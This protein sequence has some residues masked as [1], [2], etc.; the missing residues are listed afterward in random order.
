DIYSLSLHDALPISK[1]RSLSSS[2]ISIFSMGLCY[3][4]RIITMFGDVRLKTPASARP[5]Y[6]IAR[7]TWSPF[8]EQS[9][10]RVSPALSPTVGRNKDI[11]CLQTESP[12]E[13]SSE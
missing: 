9:Q 13:S 6:A 10:N 3:A 2:M 8:D 11:S 12:P 1:Q 4:V 7:G 5:E